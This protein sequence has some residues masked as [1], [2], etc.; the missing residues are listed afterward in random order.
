[1]SAIEKVTVILQTRVLVSC[2]RRIAEHKERL[3]VFSLFVTEVAGQ[4][5]ILHPG[6]VFDVERAILKKVLHAHG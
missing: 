2:Q 1:M 4:N 3:G 6:S 5:N